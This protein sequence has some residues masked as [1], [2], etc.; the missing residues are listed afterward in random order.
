MVR[1]QPHHGLQERCA[2][3]IGQRDQTDLSKAEVEGSLENRIDRWN[4]RLYQII[5]EM[6][7]ADREQDLE[8][9]RA[10]CVFRWVDSGLHAKVAQASACENQSSATRPLCASQFLRVLFDL[11][12]CL[13]NLVHV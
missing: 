4:E 12:H 6:A 9:N 11:P 13:G 8:R 1:I 10:C 2:Q 7:E 3:L 5:Q